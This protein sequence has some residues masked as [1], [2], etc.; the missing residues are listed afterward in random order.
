MALTVDQLKLDKSLVDL[1][2]SEIIVVV[3]YSDFQDY[4]TYFLDSILS[5]DEQ[6]RAAKYILERPRNNFIITRG[7]LRLLLARCLRCGPKDI[8][9][10]KNDYGKPFINKSPVFFNVS[11]S[12]DYCVIAL[13]KQAEI[14]IDIEVNN[15]SIDKAA[16][17]NRF[18]SKAEKE[19]VFAQDPKLLHELFYRTWT[20]KEAVCKA[21]GVGL[22]SVKNMF[23]VIASSDNFSVDLN[24]T[25]NN[26]NGARYFVKKLELVENYWSSVALANTDLSVKKVFLKL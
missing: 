4:I 15:T 13:S 8:V 20:A 7:L 14:G 9:F 25:L 1:D 19:W 2:S 24:A 11:H 10:E 21:L 6:D 18:F 12:G 17:I 16:I 3:N 22:W 5:K 26:M 23:S